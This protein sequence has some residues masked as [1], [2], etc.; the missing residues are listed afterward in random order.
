[1]GGGLGPA[2]MGGMGGAGGEQE[3]LDR[4]M[5]QIMAEYEPASQAAAQRAVRSLPTLA[6][7]AKEAA[8]EPGEGQAI[9]RAGEPC[10]VW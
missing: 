9:A 5:S 7:R 10:S 4:M 2:G 1:M 6:V 8:G 3:W